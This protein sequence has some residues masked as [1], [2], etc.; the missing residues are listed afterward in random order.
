MYRGKSDETQ[1]QQLQVQK[2][3][4]RGTDTQFFAPGTGSDTVVVIG[5]PLKSVTSCWFQDDSNAGSAGLLT[6]AAADLSIVNTSDYGGSGTADAIKVTGI[7]DGL[8]PG[9]PNLGLAST[10]GIFANSAITNSVGTS[11]VNGDLGESPGSTVTGAFTV[12]GSTNLGNGAAALAR[13]DAITAYTTMAALPGYVTIANVLDGQGLTAGNYD[14]AAGAVTLANAGNG[15]L[16]LTGSATDVFIFKAPSSLLTGAGG[17]PTMTLVGVSASNVYWL[18]GS[19]ATINIGVTS[20]GSTFVGT[21]I[22]DASITVTQTSV[23]SGRLIA[24]VGPTGAVTLSNPGTITVPAA[25]GGVAVT[26]ADAFYLKYIT[27]N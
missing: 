27:T 13:T 6:V 15:T 23:I 1:Q 25:S 8:P 14:F 4:V 2:L 19:S 17:I 24:G 5:Q 22:A 18:V 20:A 12:T 26:G 9:S 3:V 16:T 10:Y 11:V 21:V 7:G